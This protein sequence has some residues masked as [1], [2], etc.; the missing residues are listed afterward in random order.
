MSIVCNLKERDRSRFF[1]PDSHSYPD[2]NS[3]SGRKV[4]ETLSSVT[5]VCNPVVFSVAPATV[6]GASVR[7]TLHRTGLPSL[8]GHESPSAHVVGLN[9]MQKVGDDQLPLT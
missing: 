5:I 4:V 9:K 2:N 7:S 8:G 3:P 1:V 6:A